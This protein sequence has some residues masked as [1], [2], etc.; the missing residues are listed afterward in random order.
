MFSKH[1]N[2]RKRS[3]KLME[4]YDKAYKVLETARNELNLQEI[5]FPDRVNKLSHKVKAAEK[6]LT[7][8]LNNL[9]QALRDERRSERSLSRKV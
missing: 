3:S 6:N 9:K 5:K 4:E 2:T 7:K 8:K 1:V